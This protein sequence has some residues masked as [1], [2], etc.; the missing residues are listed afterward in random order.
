MAR[1]YDSAAVGG[2]RDVPDEI[3]DRVM[4]EVKKLPE[5]TDG[6]DGESILLRFGGGFV[7]LTTRSS[8]SAEEVK[9]ALQAMKLMDFLDGKKALDMSG[10]SNKKDLG[11]FKVSPALFILNLEGGG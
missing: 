1:K 9:R 3:L 10:G 8:A 5:G 4:E 11:E 6:A 2:E 7:V